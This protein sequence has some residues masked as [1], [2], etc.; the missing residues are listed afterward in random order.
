M[1]DGQLKLKDGESLNHETEASVDVTVT[2][3]DKGGLTTDQ[4]FTITVGDVNEKPFDLELSATNVAENTAGAVI[5]NLSVTDVD[6]GDSHEYAVSDERFE[7]VDGQLKLKDGESLLFYF[8]SLV[9]FT[10]PV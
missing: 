6:A 7:V 3:T 9:F 1:V 2:A 5:G 8:L 4:V 10:T